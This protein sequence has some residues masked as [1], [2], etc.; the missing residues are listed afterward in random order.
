[1]VLTPSQWCTATTPSLV[2]SCN[3]RIKLTL[4]DHVI[5][6]VLQVQTQ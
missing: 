1:M 4:V 2:A 3:D 6:T 5:D